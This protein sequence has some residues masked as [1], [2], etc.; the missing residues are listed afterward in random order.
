LVVDGLVALVAVAMAVGIVGT[1]VPVVPGLMLVWA[2]GLAYGLAAGFGP[3]G[4]AAF[5]VMTL[6]AVAGLVAGWVVPH[7]AAGRAG[8]PR[9][10]MAVA[11]VCAVVG[12]FVVPVVGLPLGGLAGLYLAELQRTSD[13]A[14]AWR[15][16]RSTL[17]AFGL[18]SL[19]QLAA[20][21]AMA[22]VWVAWV[23]AA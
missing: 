19:M 14:I 6:L 17:V 9:M 2:A 16:T 12:F 1:V 5:A 22:L 4:V 23:V 7:R 15:T 21:V 11:A 8:A 13:A 3:V 10:S 18:A 20:G